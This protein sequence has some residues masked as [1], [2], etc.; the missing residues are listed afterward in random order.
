MVDWGFSKVGKR[1]KNAA[2][3][4]KRAQNKK[5]ESLIEK[6]GLKT[7]N[8]EDER[9]KKDSYPLFLGFMDTRLAT[10][11]L[12]AKKTFDRRNMTTAQ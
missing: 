6:T 2:V 4:R 3:S 7:K 5:T 1:Q 11:E 8:L 9:L 10:G 12:F